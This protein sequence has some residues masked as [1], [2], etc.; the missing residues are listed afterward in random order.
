M[1]MRQNNRTIYRFADNMHIKTCPIL[2]LNGKL[3]RNLKKSN[4]LFQ[5][6]FQNLCE[7]MIQTV[8]IDISGLDMNRNP[9][10]IAKC[11]YLNLN[12]KRDDKCI[13]ETP[14]FLPELQIQ[15]AAIRIHKVVFSDYSV[16]K[17]HKNPVEQFPILKPLTSVLPE[18]HLREQYYRACS[19][20]SDTSHNAYALHEFFD[21]WT[22]T[23]GSI[24]W[25]NE[26]ECHI[27]GKPKKWIQM[28]L[29]KKNLQ[30]C[31]DAYLYEKQESP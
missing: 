19:S 15:T 23:C 27:C 2:L 29:E 3:S 31:Y 25:N 18:Q 14:L 12:L 26:K 13:R 8:C 11:H 6:K 22:C 20:L 5:L 10:G 7:K 24:N 21:F 4:F 16:W 9:I 28:N 17:D 30:K 1:E